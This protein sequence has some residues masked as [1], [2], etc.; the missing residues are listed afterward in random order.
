MILNTVA[1][2]YLRMFLAM[3]LLMPSM[4][5]VQ[6]PLTYPGSP[7][8]SGEL[9]G[10]GQKACY[11][12]TLSDNSVKEVV[13]WEQAKLILRLEPCVGKPHMQVSVYGCP[14]EGGRVVWEYM[15]PKMRNDLVTQGKSVPKDWEWVGDV[16]SL[17][18]E[19]THR[20]YYIEIVH[21]MEPYPA[22]D[23]QNTVA[24]FRLEAHLLD[25]AKMPVEATNPLQHMCGWN[26]TLSVTPRAEYSPTVL[27]GYRTALSENDTKT[28]IEWYPPGQGLVGGVPASQCPWHANISGDFEYQVYVHD[29]TDY[30]GTSGVDYNLHKAAGDVA[31]WIYPAGDFANVLRAPNCPP[32]DSSGRGECTKSTCRVCPIKHPQCPKEFLTNCTE[33]TANLF[34]LRALLNNT[35]RPLDSYIKQPER[36]TL[37]TPCGLLKTAHR[38]SERQLVE[39]RPPDRDGGW[40]S[41][42]EDISPLGADGKWWRPSELAA[43]GDGRL[44][45]RM[46]ELAES[47]NNVYLI[48]VAVRDRVTR[49][50]STYNTLTLQMNTAKYR[51]P[52]LTRTAV[53]LISGLAALLVILVAVFAI[54]ALFVKRKRMLKQAQKPRVKQ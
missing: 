35:L 36:Y 24:K 33:V 10:P 44:R 16:E 7:G 54:T 6:L 40:G 37:W 9:M 34:K 19:L 50:V 52:E 32:V 21:Q 39:V 3:L 47:R 46:L 11:N 53:G 41:I 49:Q 17:T 29:I 28:E 15:S 1:M 23:G 42:R 5:I 18:I 51:P 25:K 14:S 20:T 31:N 38:F 30:V 4:G 12:L 43:A 8:T 27:A 26:R 48:N 22:I 13:W 45:F 2:L